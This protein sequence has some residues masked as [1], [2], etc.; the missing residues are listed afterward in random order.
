[1][2][3]SFDDDICR[4][5]GCDDVVKINNNDVYGMD[6]IDTIFTRTVKFTQNPD[7]DGGSVSSTVTWTQA[8]VTK[9]ITLEE[10]MFEWR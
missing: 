2:V 8:G 9:S 6:G 5:S 1:M 3:D 10:Y 4:G 7:D